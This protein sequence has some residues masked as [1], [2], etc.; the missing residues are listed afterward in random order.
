MSHLNKNPVIS[1]LNPLTYSMIIN[2]QPNLNLEKLVKEFKLDINLKNNIPE[3]KHYPAFISK[4]YYQTQNLRKNKSEFSYRYPPKGKIEYD[5]V[6]EFCD[7]KG[8]QYHTVNC[9]RPFNSSLILINKT[10]KYKG[11]EIGTSYDL[12]VRKSGQKKVISKRTRSQIY[13]DNVEIFYENENQQKSVI[14]IANNGNINIISAFMDDNELPGLIVYRINEALNSNFTITDSYKYLI[15]AQFNIFPINLQKEFFINLNILSSNLVLVFKKKIKGKDVLMLNGNNYYNL[16]KYKYN[17]GDKLSKNNKIT[18]PY[19]QFILTEQ[20]IKINIMIYNRGAVQLRASYVNAENRTSPLEYSILEKIYSFLKK[21]L[22]TVIIYSNESN[23]DII[24]ND[25]KDEKRPPKILNMVD[26]KQPQKCHNRPGSG[27]SRPVPYSFYGTCPTEG[28]YVKGLKRSDGK[29]E[30]CCRKLKTNKSSPDYIGRYENILLNGYP[31]GLFGEKVKPG[32]S[33]IFIE[34]SKKVEP[35][36]FP[37]LNNMPKEDLLKF[38]Q[39]EGY[40]KDYIKFEENANLHK[41]TFKKLKPLLNLDIFESEVFMVTPIINNTIKIKLYFDKSGISYFINEFNRISESGISILPELAETEIDGYLSPFP[42]NFIFYPVD[43]NTYAG[44]KD[45]NL[46]DYY[47]EKSE[48][49]YYYLKKAIGLIESKQKSLM[50]ELNFDLNIVQGSKYFLD[51]PETSG[52]LFIAVKG[53]NTFI[54]VDNLHD[55]NLT[56]ALNV[57]KVRGNRWK[58]TVDNKTIP[59][60]LVEQGSD[61]DIEIPVAFTKKHP[62][63]LIILFKINLKRTNFKIENRKPFT[64]LE[65]LDQQINTY[66]EVIIILESIN[67]PINRSVFVELNQ[68]PLG[69]SFNNKIYYFTEI[70]QPLKLI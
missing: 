36:N 22:T 31:D 56:V 45:V 39:S 55:F 14:R 3:I 51:F 35:R 46:L 7:R 42:D 15:S 6:C 40:I 19:I 47:H 66:N 38:T 23:H 63:N 69:F 57:K 70:G 67:F 27:D 11:A 24:I 41:F 50:I 21:M 29:Y 52:L 9:W 64:P 49:R 5:F 53:N 26:G 4:S 13:F 37:G 43:I 18:N 16:T 10:N 48:C 12:I 58:I 17:S 61:N 20:N 1:E 59:N 32:D 68:D 62:N 33:A 25:I 65:I 44:N 60:N 8:P 54:W 30:P 28:Y 2:G 34:G